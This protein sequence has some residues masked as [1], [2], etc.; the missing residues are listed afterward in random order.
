LTPLQTRFSIINLAID[1][2]QPR[3]FGFKALLE[4]YRDHRVD[5]I[6]R[7]SRFQLRKAEE[8]LH[9]LEGLR[10]AVQNIDAVVEIIK[11][12]AN[13]EDA[14]QRLIDRFSLSETQARA[15]LDMRLARLTGLEIEKLEAEYEEVKTNIAWLQRVLS[16][17]KLRF[18][19]IRKE[20]EEMV[21]MYGDERRTVISDEEVGDFVAED[22]IAEEM[23]VVTVSHEGYVKRTAL[24]Q[25]RSQNRGGKGVA[26]AE[27][28]EGDFIE[29]LFV[30]STHDYI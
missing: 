28:K 3:T 2:G 8:R 5:V 9:I 23:M 24:D 18:D 1:R 7:R 20:M 17:P 27:T 16:E 19:I 25:Y 11:T 22:L 4:A 15:I 10:I 21:A 6:I 30:A 13:P 26:G 14:R 29:H 12:S